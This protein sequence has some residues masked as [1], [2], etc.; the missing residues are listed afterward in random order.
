MYC[1]LSYKASV[2]KMQKTFHSYTDHI[3]F[4]FRMHRFNIPTIEGDTCKF[5]VLALVRMP[6]MGD[7]PN[8]SV[9]CNSVQKKIKMIYVYICMH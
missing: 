9:V 4:R 2:L 1:Y 3:F 6:L 7:H 5:F 8:F